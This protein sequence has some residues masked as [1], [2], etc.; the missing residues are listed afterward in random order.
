M[1]ANQIK[2]WTPMIL[3]IAFAL[4]GVMSCTT[5]PTSSEPIESTALNIQA[6]QPD[7]GYAQTDQ[8]GVIKLFGFL[9]ESEYGDC[10]YLV[11]S[12]SEIYELRLTAELRVGSEQIPATVVG[13][14]TEDISPLCSEFPVFM[15][16][17]ITMGWDPEH[18]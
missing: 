8:L 13:Y 3:I 17:K 9:R 6:S 7:E 2:R 14:I 12:T 1:K 11:V 5:N 4:F 16:K 15:V 10:V 18:T